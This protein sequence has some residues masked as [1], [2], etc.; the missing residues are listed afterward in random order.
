MLTALEK[1]ISINVSAET[2][3]NSQYFAGKAMAKYAEICLVSNDILQNPSLTAQGVAKLEAAFAV[4][5]NTT[6]GGRR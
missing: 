6:V 1:D 2:N 5:A 3:V 4:F